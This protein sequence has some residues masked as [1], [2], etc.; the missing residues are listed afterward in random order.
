M[1]RGH[2]VEDM[3]TGR[4]LGG[5]LSLVCGCGHEPIRVTYLGVDP[6]F[7]HLRLDCEACGRHSVVKIR[8]ARS[9]PHAPIASETP[10]ETQALKR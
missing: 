1:L 9:F 4:K 3:I 5:Y 8:N 10:R 7:P 2:E 6:T